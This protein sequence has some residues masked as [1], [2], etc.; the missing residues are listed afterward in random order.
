[1]TE[2]TNNVL[3]LKLGGSLI[4]DKTRRETPRFD[5]I[6]WLAAEVREALDRRPDLKLVIGH[7][8][9]S[10]GHFAAKP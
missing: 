8:S 10:F 2:T 7:G 9:G 3:F 6:K 4:T 5:V 1:M